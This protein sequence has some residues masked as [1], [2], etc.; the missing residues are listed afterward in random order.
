MARRRMKKGLTA[1][2]AAIG[3]AAVLGATPASADCVSAEV[4]TQRPNQTK[5][6]AVGPKKCVV[7]TPYNEGVI[8]SVPA[9]D[10]AI[11]TFGVTVWVPAP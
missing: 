7:P 6:Y 9:G 11:I 3:A 8:V 5:Q 1:A 10:P 2:V 4:Y